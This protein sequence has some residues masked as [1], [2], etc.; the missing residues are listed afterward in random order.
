MGML[1]DEWERHAVALTADNAPMVQIVGCRHSW[2]LG[3]G[4]ILNVLREKSKD[5]SDE[6][7]TELVRALNREVTT[8]MAEEA[9]KVIRGARDEPN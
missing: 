6:E 7:L 5:G 8:Y 2:Y 1:A 4:F 3:V 9:L